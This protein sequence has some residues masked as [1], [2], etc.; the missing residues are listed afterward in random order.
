MPAIKKDTAVASAE[1][2]AKVRKVNRMANLDAINDYIAFGATKLTGIGLAGGGLVDYFMHFASLSTS[3]DSTGV[4]I[5]L[6]LLGAAKL[7]A[8]ALKML[9]Q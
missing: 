7:K 1:T 3:I 4:G 8:L 5:G 2:A 6:S 9:K